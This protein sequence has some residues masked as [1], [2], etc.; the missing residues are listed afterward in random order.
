VL[1]GL[2]PKISDCLEHAVAAE[3]Q[4]RSARDLETRQRYESI[5]ARWRQLARS[6]EFVER[7]QHFLNDSDSKS[8][9]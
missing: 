7:V 3:A 6:Y 4:A 9:K 8:A 1:Q 2:S 5:A